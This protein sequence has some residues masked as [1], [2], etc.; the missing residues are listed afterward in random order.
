MSEANV[1][2]S[3]VD[4]EESSSEEEEIVKEDK[5]FCH[6]CYGDCTKKTWPFCEDCNLS[7]EKDFCWCY[8]YNRC[9]D[10]IGIPEGRM[11]IC[12]ACSENKV[13]SEDENEVEKS[14]VT[15]PVENL[16]IPKYQQKAISFQKVR[17][18]T[19]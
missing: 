1:E 15:K 17:Q 5:S 11:S 6:S 12:E 7:R 16:S 3:T 18:E 9:D 19:H 4:E 14:V 8:Y 10:C 2:P 13:E